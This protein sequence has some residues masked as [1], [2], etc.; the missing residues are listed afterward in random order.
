MNDA[1]LSKNALKVRTNRS[2]ICHDHKKLAAFV[3][4][5]FDVVSGKSCGDARFD[6]NYFFQFVFGFQNAMLKTCKQFV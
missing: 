6:K 1:K 5:Y 4:F 2:E 3:V